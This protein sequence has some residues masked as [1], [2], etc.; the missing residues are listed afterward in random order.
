VRDIPELGADALALPAWS[1][2][3]P[4]NAPGVA[5]PLRYLIC[6]GQIVPAERKLAV[7]FAHHRA[8]RRHPGR[9]KHQI[10]AMWPQWPLGLVLIL[11]GVLNILDGSRLPSELLQRLHV[12]AFNSLQ[13]LNGLGESLSALG[14]TAQVILGLMLVATGFGLLRK[15]RF[16]W[17]MAILLLLISVGVNVVRH[18]WG[19]SLALQGVLLGCLVLVRRRFSRRTILSNFLFSLTSV[20]AILVYGTVGSFLLGAGFQPKITDLTTAFYFTI[21]T[22]STVGYGDI[23]PKTAEARWYVESLLVIGLGVFA[24]AIASALGPKIS[25]EL[26]RMFDPK[27]KPMELKDHVILAGEGAIARNT[28]RELRRRGVTFVQ[29]V[30]SP[31]VDK[32]GDYPILE[33]HAADDSVLRR[34]GIQKARMVIAAR[35]DDGDNAFIALVAKDLN[36]QVRLLALASSA[37]SI[38]RLKLAGA[39]LVFSPAAVGSRL[40]ANL[41]EGNEISPEFRDLLEGELNKS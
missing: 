40:L 5:E 19:V 30:A 1:F 32:A 18:N 27:V 36:S 34:A 17:T 7:N 28:A 20:L 16:A 4:A 23:V 3:S 21:V 29:I 13:A 33:G 38:R 10:K 22:L 11:V 2:C 24:G 12:H 41:V 14:A 37:A 26:Q 9:L 15:L 35:E 39:D 6:L 25:W 8:H 31:P